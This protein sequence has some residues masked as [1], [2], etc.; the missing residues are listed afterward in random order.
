MTLPVKIFRNVGLKEMWDLQEKLR[1]QILLDG[2]QNELWLVEHRP[3][4]SLGRGEKGENMFFPK[5]FL[6]EK[7]FEVAEINR[8][9]AITYHGPGQLVAYP[10]INLRDFDLGVRDY[11]H[12]L[13]QMMIETLETWNISA[14]RK[15]KA[16]GVYIANRKI[17]SVGIH[18]RKQVSIHG[19]ALN[20][21]PNLE[22]FSFIRPCGLTDIEMTSVQKEG[23]NVSLEEA[24]DVFSSVFKR[25]FPI[26][27]KSFQITSNSI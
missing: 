8:G 13:E 16:P 27:L 15:E 14:E 22:H 12:I 19:I 18:I 25:Y 4:L 9:G 23:Q 17:G 11:V 7:G 20:I 2:A 21:H 5:E 1:N 24:F 26:P 6:E 10:V 3:T